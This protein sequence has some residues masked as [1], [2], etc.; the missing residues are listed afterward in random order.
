MG[1]FKHHFMPGSFW[2]GWTPQVDLDNVKIKTIE[3]EGMLLSDFGL[4]DSQKIE[5]DYITAPEINNYDKNNANGLSL[6]KNITNVLNGYGLTGV[7]VTVDSTN[8]KGI[9]VIYNV[10]ESMK[11]TGYKIENAMNNLFGKRM[12]Y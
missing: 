3:N 10:T 11:I 4:Y 8:T 9:N 7:K 6:A 2:A 1:Y 12:F 5:A